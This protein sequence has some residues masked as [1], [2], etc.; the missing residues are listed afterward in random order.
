MAYDGDMSP[1]DAVKTMTEEVLCFCYC[2]AEIPGLW[3]I[4]IPSFE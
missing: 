4:K 1:E 3:Q 2:Q